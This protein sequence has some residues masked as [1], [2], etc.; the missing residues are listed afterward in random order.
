MGKFTALMEKLGRY[1]E[2]VMPK[3]KRKL[4]IEIEMS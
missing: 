1:E 3:P 4:D 2:D